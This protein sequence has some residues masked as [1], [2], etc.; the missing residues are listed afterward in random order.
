MCT[1]GPPDVYTPA[2]TARSA[3]ATSRIDW[4][5]VSRRFSM[6]RRITC[7]VARSTP[8]IWLGGCGG[9]VRC[10]VSTPIAL[11]AMNGSFPVN[12]RYMMTP[13]E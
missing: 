9:S 2:R 1:S 12:A 10:C 5:R 3:A 6:H 4:K 8:E 11:S 7:S 13:S